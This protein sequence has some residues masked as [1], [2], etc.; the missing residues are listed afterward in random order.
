[1]ENQNRYQQGNMSRQGRMNGQGNMA[2]GG[3]RMSGQGNMTSG[4]NR[5][6]GQGNMAGQGNG[7]AQGN[8]PGQTSMPQQSSAPEQTNPFRDYGPVP[9]IFDMESMTKNNNSFRTAIWTGT[10]L[11]VTVMSLQPGEDIGVE[12]HPDTDQFIRIEQG[13]GIVEM[14]TSRDDLSFNQ[15]IGD[16]DAIIIPAGSWH[17]VSNTGDIVMKAYS[18]YAP[19][20]HPYGTKQQT[21]ADADKDSKE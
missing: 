12:M 2:S 16:D 9:V 14:G 4:G 18:I 5:M 1:M 20:K 7:A 19:P 15:S 21:R 3:N 11:Q 10:H 6:N 8:M 13:D 17:N